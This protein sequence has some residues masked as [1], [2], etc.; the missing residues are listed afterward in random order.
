MARL[1]DSRIIWFDECGH[2]PM[3]EKPEEFS[4]ALLDFAG[5]LDRRPG[6]QG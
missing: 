1:Q 2:T 4:R 5:E 6:G 3:I